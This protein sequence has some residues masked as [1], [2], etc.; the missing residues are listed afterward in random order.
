MG[1]DQLEGYFGD[2]RTIIHSINCDYL[3]LLERMAASLQTNR[4]LLYHPDWRKSSTLSTS[5]KDH[6][7]SQS[8]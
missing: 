2:I 6:T 8:W 1:T 3:E 5:T 4:V 7:S